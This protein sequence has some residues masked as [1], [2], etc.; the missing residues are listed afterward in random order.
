[1]NGRSCSRAAVSASTTLPFMMAVAEVIENVC[2]IT[3]VGIAEIDQFTELASFQICSTENLTRVNAKLRHRNVVEHD[4]RPWLTC[5]MFAARRRW[6]FTRDV[7]GSFE[8]IQCRL[9]RQFVL[10]AC[11]LA[12]LRRRKL[13]SLQTCSGECAV[14]VLDRTDFGIRAFDEEVVR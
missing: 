9:D 13:D 11:E 5:A 8:Q 10:L 7:S 14:D 6:R 2:P 12:Y 4:D 3:I 1:M